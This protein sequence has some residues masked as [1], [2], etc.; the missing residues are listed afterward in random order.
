MRCLDLLQR[1][2]VLLWLVIVREGRLHEFA[3]ASDVSAQTTEP[4]LLLDAALVLE[5]IVHVQ[6]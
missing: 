4:P 5:H 3:A 2:V 6:L 1:H